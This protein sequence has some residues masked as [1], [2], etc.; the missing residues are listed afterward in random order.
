M[1]RCR[2]CAWY[3]SDSPRDTVGVCHVEPPRPMG[4][5]PDGG[6][7]ISF[8]PSTFAD[9]FCSKHKDRPLIEPAGVGK[10]GPD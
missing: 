3:T 9:G 5:D 4:I 6:T 8:Q 2:D 7:P 1:K 10:F